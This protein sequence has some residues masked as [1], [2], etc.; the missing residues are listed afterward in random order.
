MAELTQQRQLLE[1]TISSLKSNKESL[2]NK[3]DQYQDNVRD[4]NQLNDQQRIR[5]EQL[6]SE[7]NDR[8]QRLQNQLNEK[9]QKKY[10]IASQLLFIPTI[11]RD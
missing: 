7:L 8:E 4:L 11:P 5:F 10:S 6:N 3:I 9:D 2:V 1:Q